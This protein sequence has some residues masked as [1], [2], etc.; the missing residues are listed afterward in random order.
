MVKFLNSRLSIPARLWLMV[1][2]STVPDIILTTLFV[3][4]SSIDIAFAKKEVDGTTYLSDLWTSL[5]GTAKSD[6]VTAAAARTQANYDKEFNSETAA[7]AYRTST[8]V[9]DRLETGKALI[10]AVADGSNL[11][12]DPDLDTFYAMDAVTVRLPGIVNAA[13]ALGKAAAQPAGSKERL[14]QIAFAVNRLEISAGD[15]DS[16]LNAAMKNN[17]AGATRAAL[18]N[19]TEEL[20]AIAT[21]LGKDGRVLLDGGTAADLSAAQ[22]KLLRQVDVTWRATS[23]ELARLL[24]VRVSGFYHKLIMSL[25]IAAVP[26]CIDYWLSR[27]VARGLTRRVSRLVEVMGHLTVED[28][29]PEIPYL[30]DRNE[31]GK[32]AAALAAFRASIDERKKLKSEQALASEQ[33][34]VVDAVAKA[35]ERLARGDLT[36]CVDEHFPPEYDKMRTN[37]NATADQLRDSMLTIARSTHTIQHSTTRFAQSTNDLARRTELQATAL[38]GSA[39]TLNEITAMIQH[40]AQE[41][42][43]IQDTVS[44]VKAQAE[45][46]EGVVREAMDAMNAIQRSAQEIGDIIGVM[47]EIASQTNLLALNAGIE[48]ARAGQSGRGFAVVAAEVRDL[49]ERSARA[50]KQVR[51]LISTSSKHVRNGAS[52]VVETG[53]ALGNIVTQIGVTNSVMT[54]IAFGASTQAERL[55]LVNASIGQMDKAVQSNAQMVEDTTTAARLLQSETERLSILIDKFK[56]DPG[57]YSGA[58]VERWRPASLVA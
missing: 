2:V 33:A 22:A 19:F 39:S 11:T 51:A 57:A 18:A 1:L 49:A 14:V 5:I 46:G 12:L 9:A 47:D 16:S 8:N 3:Q 41:A 6:S 34:R 48:A 45:G 54:S 31:T 58:A 36:I 24:L 50:A 38:E 56:I 25:L 10:G 40:S 21:V 52:L 4:Q 15:A 30:S 44:K 32:I 42:I 20:K 13:V 23:A 7:E 26:L 43:D 29:S 55:K 28:T 35:L 17:A 27:T 53:T 37:L